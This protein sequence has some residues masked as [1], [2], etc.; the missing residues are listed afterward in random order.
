[1]TRAWRGC[2]GP[3]MAFAVLLAGAAAHEPAPARAAEGDLRWTAAPQPGE[4]GRAAIGCSTGTTGDRWTCLVVRCEDDGSLGV[5]Y[6]HSDGGVTAPFSLAID[7]RTFAVTPGPAPQGVPFATRLEGDAGAI[8]AGLRT[9]GSV[10]LTGLVPPL[11]PGFDTIPLRSSGRAI[12]AVAAACARGGKGA[13]VAGAKL[14]RDS[15]G[16]VAIGKLSSA[17]GCVRGKGSGTV[18]ALKEGGFWFVDDKYGRGYINVDPPRAGRNLAIRKATLAYL[19]TPG[20]RLDVDVLACG[21]AG[22]IEKLVAARERSDGAKQPAAEA[23]IEDAAG[24][25]VIAGDLS[26]PSDT[27]PADLSVCAERID[28]KEVFCTARQVKSKGKRLGY[29]LSVPAGV[30]HVYAT[31]PPGKGAGTSFDNG[32]RAYYSEHTL[33]GHDASCPSHAPVAV[34]VEAGGTSGDI[35]PSDW[36]DDAQRKAMAAGADD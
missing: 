13:P 25:G 19:L 14:L 6:D 11:N 24:T 30:Y 32:Y 3:A 2:R 16:R 8:A 5:Y 26:Y 23:A 22:R 27:I 1:M 28:T 34:A 17:E 35:S 31:F 29:R 18:D 12:G 20:R 10:T 4:A 21:A 15:S 7:G 9:G 36:Y 33:C